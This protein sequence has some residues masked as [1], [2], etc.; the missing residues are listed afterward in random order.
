MSPKKPDDANTEKSD[1]DGK[2]HYFIGKVSQLS[3]HVD[4][5]VTFTVKRTPPPDS[6]SKDVV[7]KDDG[8]PHFDRMVKLVEKSFESGKNIMIV[9]GTDGTVLEIGM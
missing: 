9:F 6:Q 1:N 5:T 8:N 3:F 2:K 4:G 7:L